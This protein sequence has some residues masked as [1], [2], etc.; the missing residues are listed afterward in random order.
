MLY[1]K[2]YDK[3]DKLAAVTAIFL[4]ISMSQILINLCIFRKFYLT[5]FDHKKCHCTVIILNFFK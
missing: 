4:L 5:I 2:C 3:Y 1:I